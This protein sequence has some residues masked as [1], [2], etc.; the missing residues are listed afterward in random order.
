MAFDEELADRV[1]DMLSPREGLSER[2]MFGGIGFMLNGNMA[3]GVLGDDLIVRLDPEDAERALA[4][5]DVRVFDYSGRPMK[6]WLFV[7]PAATGS[8]AGLDGWVEAG[9]DH[10]ASLPPKDRT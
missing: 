4:E 10:A 9:A 5:E 1:R 6:G 3:C 8:A 2:K 7:G